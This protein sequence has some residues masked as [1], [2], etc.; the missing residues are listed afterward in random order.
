M[1]SRIELKM[2]MKSRKMILNLKRSLKNEE[3]YI[4][5]KLKTMNTRSTKKF[6]INFSQILKLN[7]SNKFIKDV[8]D[9]LNDL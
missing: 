5:K 9:T 7:R 1:I 4:N 8:Y 2:S 6:K 3:R